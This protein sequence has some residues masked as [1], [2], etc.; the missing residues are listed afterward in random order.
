MRLLVTG[1]AGF[2][3]SHLSARLL[4]RGD[5]VVGLDCFD[6]TLYPAALH[7]ANIDAIGAHE[8]FELVRGDFL[9]QAVVDRAFATPFDV[10][11]HL[12]AL[13]GVRP[14]IAQPKRYQ[15]TN[16]EGTLN[17]LEACRER[18]I[19]R[20]V[21]ASSSSVY[22][23]RSTVPF[24]EDDNCDMPAS[25]YAATKRMGEILCATYAELFRISIS[26]LRFFTVYGP[27]QRPEMAIHQF[28]RLI[29]N[30]Q[31]I[32]FFGDGNSRR[33]YT[34]VDD[35]VSG[36]TGAMQGKQP[37]AIY[38]LGG[39][40]TTSLTELVA[41]LERALGR[42]AKKKQLPDQPGDVPITFADVTLAERELG[43]RCTTPLAA[44]I[45]KFCAWYL[46]E[47]RAGRIP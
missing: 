1:A 46:A 25:P 22:G 7:Q 47:K 41:H 18:R 10:V 40:A 37:Y 6:E 20:V 8:R 38:N 29:S 42:P 27:R 16:I 28:A 14:S 45:D 23:S 31:E 2:I 35:I 9:D 34:Y 26:A 19:T 21:F 24:R 33:D 43:Y 11:V 39:S 17:L 32:P 44:G 12:G 4:A 30:G 13:A 3:G 5:W 36:I 15:R